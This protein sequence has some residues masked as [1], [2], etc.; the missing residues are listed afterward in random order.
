MLNFACF[1]FNHALDIVMK[2]I[3][4]FIATFFLGVQTFS[5]TIRNA[6]EYVPFFL[7]VFSSGPLTLFNYFVFYLEEKLQESP[8]Y[9]I[10]FF[11]TSFPFKNSRCG[12]S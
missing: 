6:H 7:T 8:F 12:I 2:Y 10:S 9:S 1:I 3:I 5:D 11:E 4:F